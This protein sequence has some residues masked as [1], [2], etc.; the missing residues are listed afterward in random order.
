MHQAIAD[1]AGHRAIAAAMGHVD[2][3]S[4]ELERLDAERQAE[5]RRSA[6]GAR[7]SLTP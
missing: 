6:G 7:K 2:H 3:G 1:V 4:V 5:A